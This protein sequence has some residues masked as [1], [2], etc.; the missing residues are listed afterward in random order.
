M[1]ILNPLYSPE[2]ASGGGPSN[3]SEIF[4]H[5]KAI[6]GQM[7]GQKRNLTI[8]VV[9]LVLVIV[10]WGATYMMQGREVTRLTDEQAKMAS[11]MEGLKSENDQ[12]QSANG[13]L[14]QQLEA[15]QQAQEGQ[16][17]TPSGEASAAP[18]E[19]VDQNATTHVIQEGE[20][21][22]DIAERFFGNGHKFIELAENNYIE[23][24]D[25]VLA[26]TEIKLDINVN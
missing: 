23:D 7:K 11:D 2:D 20:T 16:S 21:L 12:L 10:G 24:P 9:A 13:E 22:W 19:P 18:T 14:K 15:S 8:V 6:D 4:D 26:G 5:I 17:E 3:E 25:Y 1:K